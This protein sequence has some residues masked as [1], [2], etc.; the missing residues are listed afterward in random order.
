MYQFSYR[1]YTL[2]GPIAKSLGRD[3]ALLA[4]HPRPALNITSTSSLELILAW[5]GPWYLH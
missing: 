5:L 4:E 1:F 2:G 3:F